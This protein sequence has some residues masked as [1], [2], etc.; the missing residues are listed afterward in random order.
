[1][2]VLLML[3][4][5]VVSLSPSLSLCYFI[6]EISLVL[7]ILFPFGV[8]GITFKPISGNIYHVYSEINF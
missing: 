7:T 2:L 6:W 8:S 4:I 5:V 3:L 1:M